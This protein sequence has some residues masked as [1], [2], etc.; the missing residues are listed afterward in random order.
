MVV[1][2]LGIVPTP[3]PPPLPPVALLVVVAD[4]PPVAP[5]D[6]L[7]VVEAVSTWPPAPPSDAIEDWPSPVVPMPPAP[8]V[9]CN[10]VAL[11]VPPFVCE[12]RIV[13]V[14]PELIEA[15][16]PLPP[17]SARPAP[18]LSPLPQPI[19]NRV[20]KKA[21]HRIGEPF[22]EANLGLGAES[23]E[24]EETD[25]SVRFIMVKTPGDGRPRYGW[26]GDSTVAAQVR[27]ICLITLVGASLGGSFKDAWMQSM[28][29][30]GKYSVGGMVDRTGAASLSE[31]RLHGDSRV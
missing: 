25:R 24:L 28:V 14:P 20:P 30:Q 3:V 17:A 18:L 22:F 4:A 16:P 8:P 27:Q 15:L 5:V 19:V 26:L 6:L 1:Q 7:E 2:L 31:M 12:V 29:N 23:T 11:A 21:A 10:P 13:L 9:G